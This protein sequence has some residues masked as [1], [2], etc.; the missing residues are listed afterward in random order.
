MHRVPFHEGKCRALHGH[1]YAAELTF[2]ADT[3][4]TNGC[5]VD[6]GLVKEV[7]GGW[8][9]ERWDHTGLFQGS[10]DHEAVR[11]VRELNH[12]LG[13]PCYVFLRPPTAEVIAE[14]LGRKVADLLPDFEIV[15]VRVWETPNCSAEWTAP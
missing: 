9:D 14:F 13:R 2:R 7:V 3:L 15:R 1:R 10:D 12:E 6:F 8:I 11:A 5:V 4:D